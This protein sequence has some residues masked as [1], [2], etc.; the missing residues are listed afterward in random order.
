MGADVRRH[1]AASYHL[2]GLT[3]YLLAS[4]IALFSGSFSVLLAARVLAAFGAAVRFGR[5]ANGDSR[6]LRRL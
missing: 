3:L 1:R 5:D 6:S 2:A 4:I